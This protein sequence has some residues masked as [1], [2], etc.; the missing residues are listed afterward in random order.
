[1]SD[2]ED[3]V[4]ENGVLTKYNG[5]G[6]DVVI[7]D[8]VVEISSG[9]FSKCVRLT[10]VI[11][12]ECVIKIG[13]GAFFHCAKLTG[14]DI[15][16]SVTE[17]GDNVFYGCTSLVR[18]KLPESLTK[19]PTRT[20]ENCSSLTNISIPGC[21][22]MICSEAFKGCT[23]LESI[24]IPESV[25]E[26]GHEAFKG[27]TGLA[28]INIP[29]SINKIGNNAFEDCRSC[30]HV[31]N[32]IVYMEKWVVGANQNIKNA[33][34][35]DGTERI[36]D[37][38]FSKC[39][40]LAEIKIPVSITT[41]GE[42][43]FSECL[44]L[45]EINIPEG[46]TK[47]CSYAFLYCHDLA[48][49]TIPESVTDIGHAAFSECLSL[50]EI[51]IPEGVTKIGG[52]AF[53]NCSSL[54]A[55]NIPDCVTEIWDST[56]EGCTNLAMINIP[57]NVTKIGYHAFKGCEHLSLI[58]DGNST[59][60]NFSETVRCSN[61]VSIYAP[62]IPLDDFEGAKAKKLV[63][64]GYMQ[65]LDIEDA[66]SEELRNAY[67][68][69]IKSHKDF[70]FTV[71]EFAENNAP[72]MNF[73]TTN[74]MISIKEYEKLMEKVSKSG[75]AEVK[76]MLLE[77]WNTAFSR[78]QRE[79]QEEQKFSYHEPTVSELKEL[80]STKKKVD[81]TLEI[82]G[83]KGTESDLIIPSFIGK[84]KVTSIG[85]YAFSPYAK[86]IK[87]E[88]S[89]KEIA[90]VIIPEGITEIGRSAFYKCSNL[91]NI[92]I[93]KGVTE[94]GFQV[95]CYCSNLTRI[96]L[97]EGVTK[98]GDSAFYNCSG[99][100]NIN[101][102]DSVTVI[103]GEAFSDCSSLININIPDSVTVIGSGAFSDCSSLTNV[104]IP[105]GVTK[106]NIGAFSDCI[107]LTSIIIPQSVLQIEDSCFKNCTHLSLFLEGNSIH[108]DLKKAFKGQE[109]P[110]IYAPK[111]PLNDFEG[112]K[113]RKYVI[114]GYLKHLDI[115]D[116][117]SAEQKTSYISYVK[118]H[119]D[120]RFAA[121]EEAA[122]NKYAMDFL[123]SN[124]L[125]PLKEYDDLME[126]VSASGSAEIQSMLLE[127]RNTTFS[128][129]R[130]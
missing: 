84:S 77:Y 53:R 30:T 101:I 29:E 11:I 25:T 112:T 98:I 69:Y 34:I 86:K 127:Y 130:K 22:A 33:I 125:I 64:L 74:R 83:Y 91:I 75:N 100:I 117:L 104:N 38:A 36:A 31:I 45:T 89:R 80:W 85:E 122:G 72:V 118:S 92:N 67:I 47:I 3:F 54:T 82:S 97:P 121:Y 48:S 43:A 24:H 49:V 39:C 66:V 13:G 63:I 19:I 90:S 6:G 123:V 70:R 120:A 52:Y 107:N 102:P 79:K 99:L 21:T 27:C 40:K 17:I 32:K 124:K 105:I 44:S 73:L 28:S 51:N 81:G 12:P 109:Y 55:I 50:T 16:E 15:P 4:I 62:R 2:I 7:P 65:H 46:I 129:G 87:N 128:K 61:F 10:R 76:S 18:V 115:E 108:F 111:I 1:M 88:Q 41:I 126:T 26:I 119:K 106:I 9:A 116:S 58:L 35:Q 94:I 71:Y 114:L 56:F 103:G 96:T 23:S 60:V 5:P 57:K 110:P 59:P 93:P 78:S 14:I 20:F 37:G 8:G 42:S 113:I 68:K 95:F